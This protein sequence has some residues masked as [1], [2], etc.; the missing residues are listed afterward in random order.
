MATTQTTKIDLKRDRKNLYAPPKAPVLVEVPPLTFL[1]VDGQGDP[2]VSVAYREAIEALYAVSYTLKFALKRGPGGLDYVVMPLEGLW[3]ADD[4]TEFSGDRKA[5][6]RWTAMIAQPDAVTPE[7]AAQAVAECARKQDLPA[8]ARLRLETLAEGL[9]AQ[10][11]YVGPYQD[12]GPAIAHLHAFIRERGYSFDGRRQK[13]HEIY[14]SDPR[15]TAPP[16]LKTVIRQPVVPPA[17]AG[18]GA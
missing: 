11:L 5:D 10:V 1:M 2:N 8:L 13:H 18:E 17:V 4:K 12:E 16:K 3:W 6:W 15:R 14:L 7:L 9:S